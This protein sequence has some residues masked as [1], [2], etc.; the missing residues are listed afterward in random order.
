MSHPTTSETG[1]HHC[2]LLPGKLWFAFVLVPAHANFGD[3]S[4]CLSQGSVGFHRKLVGLF[5]LLVLFSFLT[6]SIHLAVGLLIGR[7]VV[8]IL[9]VVPGIAPRASWRCPISP[10]CS[11]FPRRI[12]RPLGCSIIGF[13]PSRF[14]FFTSICIPGLPWQPDSIFLE[15]LGESRA[16]RTR[17]KCVEFLVS[18]ITC[19]LSAAD[20]RAAFST[21]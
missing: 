19:R 7:R 10:V 8:I 20:K 2:A 9:I 3:C 21:L 1:A 16:C 5:G 12:I 18:V 4:L 15:V 6:T 13:I 11:I 14:P 17:L